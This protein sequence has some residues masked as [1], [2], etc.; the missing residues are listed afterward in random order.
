MIDDNLE[1]LTPPS[2]PL[3]GGESKAPLQEV[4]L[5]PS[6][7]KGR[8]G[9]GLAFLPYNKN[10]TA[11]ARENRKNPT[12][13]ETKI[14]NEVL[15]MRQF[16]DY[17]FLRQKPLAGYIVDFYCSELRLVIEID[18]DSHAESVEYDAERTRVLQSL[19][20]TVIRYTNGEVIS[21]IAGMFDDLCEKTE[22]LTNPS[23]ALPLTGEGV[24]SPPLSRG[25][26]GARGVSLEVD[27]DD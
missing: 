9:E 15:R 14:W 2:P 5:S 4:G 26:R 22:K 1:K 8:V 20:L 13:A 7:V 19:G 3:T 18:G 23:P 21:N 27:T 10:L 12:P 17:K 6:P 11:L 16:A 24:I 25:A